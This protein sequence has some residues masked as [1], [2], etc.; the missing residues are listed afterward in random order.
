VKNLIE[1]FSHRSGFPLLQ[2]MLLAQFEIASTWRA[3]DDYLPDPEG[4][5]EDI[6]RVA[7]Q[8]LIPER[9]TA[10]VLTPLPPGKETRT[11]PG[12]SIKSKTVR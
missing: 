12:F 5:S 6:Q 9:R 8:Y 10:G 2:A 11:A 3:V 7:N 1:I 4:H